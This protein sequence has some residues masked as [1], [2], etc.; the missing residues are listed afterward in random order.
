M[1]DAGLKTPRLQM[2]NVSTTST[3]SHS[4]L[5]SVAATLVSALESCGVDYRPV[6]AEADMDPDAACNPSERIRTLQRECA[7][8]CFGLT[9]AACIQSS[10]LHGL[11]LSW[12][13]MDELQQLQDIEA[14]C[15]NDSAVGE[16]RHLAANGMRNGSTHR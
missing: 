11:G 10:S 12:I 13:G 16:A 5:A 4:T 7:A 9:C 14:P 3:Q 2:D 15:S 8:P 6:L 1:T